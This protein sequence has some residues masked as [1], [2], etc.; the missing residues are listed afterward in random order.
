[1]KLNKKSQT[2]PPMVLI[3]ILIVTGYFASGSGLTGGI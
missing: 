2:S 3:Q 1:M